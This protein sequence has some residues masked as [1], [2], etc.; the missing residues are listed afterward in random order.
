MQGGLIPPSQRWA[1][2]LGE[3]GHQRLPVLGRPLVEFVDQLIVV[4]VDGAGGAPLD[5]VEQLVD[6]LLPVEVHDEVRAIP[7]VRDLRLGQHFGRFGLQIERPLAQ[8]VDHLLLRGKVERVG[9][10]S[11]IA[12]G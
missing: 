7:G 12:H 1:A 11:L 9:V 5:G 8:L 10:I 6:H 3:L 4:L 2:R